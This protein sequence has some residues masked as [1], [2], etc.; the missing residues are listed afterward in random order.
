[1]TDNGNLWEDVQAA[2]K[3]TGALVPRGE[4]ASP[5]PGRVIAAEQGVREFPDGKRETYQRVE[6]DQE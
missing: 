1:M 5:A 3:V 4:P 6:F 2:S